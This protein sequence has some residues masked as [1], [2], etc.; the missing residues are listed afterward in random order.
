MTEPDDRTGIDPRRWRIA[1]L[2]LAGMIVLL[3]FV[4]A[5]QPMA[6]GLFPSPWDKLAHFVCYAGI[7]GLL[8]VG[9]GDCQ[10]WLLVA[11]VA[12]LGALDEWHQAYLPGR[13]A[14]LPDL[15]TDIA[16]AIC[17]ATAYEMYRAQRT[18]AV[19]VTGDA[20]GYRTTE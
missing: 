5:A 7:T 16:A 12:V 9:L 18:P 4:L 11:T 1:Q 10:P 14:D 13:S 19:G 20:A 3:L 15:L 2:A 17:V 8:A 6:A